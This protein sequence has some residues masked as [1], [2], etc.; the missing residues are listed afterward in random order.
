VVGCILCGR[1]RTKVAKTVAIVDLFI[2][3]DEPPTVADIAKV[4]ADKV[5]W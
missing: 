3:E 1:E 4:D 2:K 5:D